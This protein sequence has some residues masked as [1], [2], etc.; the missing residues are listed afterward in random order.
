MKTELHCLLTAGVLVAALF[1]LPSCKKDSGNSSAVN[2][3]YYLSASVSGTSWNANVGLDSLH[4]PAI[5]ALNGLN[6]GDIAVVIAEE[7]SGKDTSAFV[8]VFPVE[9]PLNQAWAFNTANLALAA[10]APNASLV[11]QTP[12]T[13]NAGDSVTVTTFDQT[14]QVIEGTFKGTFY[15]TTGSGSVTITNGK[16]RAPY[17][18]DAAQQS[19]LPGN[20][21]F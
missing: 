2:S 1:T 19:S 21:K 8:I 11:Y 20:I 7:A 10:Y 18:I 12:S 14:N 13:G 9:I 4:D 6:T 5:A 3:A 16:F 15:S 17:V